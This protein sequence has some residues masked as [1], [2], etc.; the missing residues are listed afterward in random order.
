MLLG[1]QPA[2]VV[3]ARAGDVRVDVHAAGHHDHA[4]RV[5]RRRAG[6]QSLDDPAVLDADVPHLAVD[7]VGR[8]VDGAAHDPEP[9]RCA[10]PVLPAL[11]AHRTRREQRGQRCPRADRGRP[12][13]GRSGSGT[14][15]MRYAMPPS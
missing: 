10:H 4:A 7:A 14:S 5:E 2:G 12:S 8:I 6:G 3:A 9:L 15:S 1:Q 13:G 11:L